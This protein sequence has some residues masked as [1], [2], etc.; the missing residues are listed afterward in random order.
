M[1]A[2]FMAENT[3]G[4]VQVD[5]TFTN[6][7]LVSATTITTTS[8]PGWSGPPI[9]FGAVHSGST[10]EDLVFV[11]CASGFSMPGPSYY[12][13]VRKVPVAT[14]AAGIAVTFYIYRRQAPTGSNFGLQVFSAASALLFDAVSKFC[15][16]LATLATKNNNLA[17]IT[18]ISVGSTLKPAILMP[19]FTGQM[20]QQDEGTGQGGIP[21]WRHISLRGPRFVCQENGIRLL[22]YVEFAHAQ[23]PIANPNGGTVITN[24]A[25]G[26]VVVIDAGNI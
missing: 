2:G 4:T 3:F 19:S 24:Y 6:Y 1:T 23:I 26:E 10:D 13:G 15:K 21:G 12:Q 8:N 11:H 7:A 5:D 22:G 18:T 17:Q 25:G 14:T 16:V 9:P 20:V